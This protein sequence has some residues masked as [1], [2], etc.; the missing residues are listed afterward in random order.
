MNLLN[1]TNK[2]DVLEELKK[3]NTDVLKGMSPVQAL[4]YG[5][6]LQGEVGQVE[7][8]PINDEA[9]NKAMLDRMADT[10]I[11]ERLIKQI[12]EEKKVTS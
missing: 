1:L 4:Q 6:A 5:L 10:G 11:K 2:V 8:S 7:E 3:G 9:V 12:E